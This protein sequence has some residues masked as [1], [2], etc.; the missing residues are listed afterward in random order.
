MKQI[1]G[2]LPPSTQALEGITVLDFSHVIA[3]PF[4]TY[5]LAA[6][7]ARV[8]KIENPSGGDVIRRNPRSFAALN[9]GKECISLDLQKTEDIAR[10][11]QLAATSDVM[12]DNMRPGVLASYGL[13]VEQ[14]RT[15]NPRL[16]HCSI[17]GYGAV[18]EWANRGA[19][20]H[21]IQAASGMTMMSGQATDGPIKV[22]FPVVDCA[23]GMLA[24]FAILAAIRRRDL[25]GLGETIDV[26][27]LAAAMQLMYP[28]VV[29]TLATGNSPQRKGNVGY[30][31]SP[32][33]ETLVCADGLLA[34]GANTPAQLM[35]LGDALGIGAPIRELLEGQSTGFVTASRGEEIRQLLAKAVSSQPVSELEVRLNQEGVP[36][37]QV[38]DLAQSVRDAT[39]SG[40][41]SS[42]M[43]SG[44]TPVAVP[45]L[46][47]RAHS[48]FG[49]ASEPKWNKPSTHFSN[50][51]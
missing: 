34:I 33:A 2:L 8:I 26:S 10:A 9:H 50:K 12:V 5:H 45:G 46:G 30:S 17:S 23:T 40:A 32:A 21:V 48:L 28:M 25:T 16:I 1:E 49:G 20:D 39:Q 13:G 44:E 14:M 22:G 38:R 47:F 11:H 31:G 37:A 4:A 42:W 41:M 51:P 19:Y 43:L 3:G 24:A 27:M 29:D 6:L 36:A 7:G 35:K 18:G 15:K